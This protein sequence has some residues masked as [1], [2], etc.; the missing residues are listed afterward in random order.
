MRCGCKNE[1]E[2]AYEASVLFLGGGV[3]FRLDDG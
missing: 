3:G 1:T 2:L